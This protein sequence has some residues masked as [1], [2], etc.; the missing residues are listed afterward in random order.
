MQNSFGVSSE[1]LKTQEEYKNKVQTVL[2][3]RF[4]LKPPCAYVRTYG[5]QGNVADGEMIKGI[6]ASLGY[7]ITEDI[8]KA[9]LILYNTCAIREHAED[10]VFG[11]VGRLKERKAANPNLIIALCGCMMQQERV[12]ERIKRSFRYVDLVF[13]THVLFKLPEFIY[14]CLCTGERV[15]DITDGNGCIIE[16]LPVRRDGSFKAWVPIMY[17]CNNFCSY[18]IVPY[19]RGRE[20]SRD[21][22]IV[23]EECRHLVASGYKE[24]T[25]LGQNVNSYNRGFSQKRSFPALL[26]AIN[27]LDGDFIIRFMTSHPKDCS[28]ELLDTIKE[29]EKVERH[30]H[31][32]V[33]SGNDR[34]L[35]EMNRRYDRKKYLSLIDYAYGIMPD[36][37]ITSDIIVGFPGETYNEF[38]DTLSLIEKVK[39]TSL[40]TFIFSPR[41]G[42]KAFDLDD[43][44]SRE[45]KG[46]WF[47]ELI[48]LQEGIASKRTKEM[49]GKT[50]RVLVEEKSKKPSFLS[51]RT[52]GNVII[53]FEGDDSLIGS[54]QN[55]TVTETK[56]WVVYG[57]IE[58]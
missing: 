12:A 34:V 2:S 18:C 29:C 31:L 37:S 39:F 53:E 45:E 19:V 25:L 5:C 52:S 32:P 44:V 55:V 3:A 33:Q 22:D 46:R 8:D 13:G 42:T 9:D 24:I 16:S 27:E 10:R 57:E 14:R 47:K 11:N 35:S 41:P 26:R 1:A 56:T 38:K 4:D 54:F 50:Y 7:E 40:Y 23:L 58:Q 6:L 17:G 21:F 36:L 15:F 20:R 48:D 49:K 51:G 28:F 43:P 30:L